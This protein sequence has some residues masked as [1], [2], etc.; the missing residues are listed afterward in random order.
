M[1]SFGHYH[2]I[3]LV[4]ITLSG[5]YFAIATGW[6]SSAVL[7]PLSLLCLRRRVST[8]KSNALV[9]HIAET[10]CLL[11]P[12]D[13]FLKEP[14]QRFTPQNMPSELCKSTAK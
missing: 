1:Q 13:G 2:K 12:V 10:T 9:Y 11:K 4:L 14:L 7:S 8:N 5:A 3:K 6:L